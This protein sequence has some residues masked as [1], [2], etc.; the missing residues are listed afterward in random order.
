MSKMSKRPT[1]AGSELGMAMNSD[2]S[3]GDR[4]T[5]LGMRTD[6]HLHN[7]HTRVF[8]NSLCGIALQCLQALLGPTAWF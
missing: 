5:Q 7:S 1:D 8:L 4:C 3:C 6:G 2:L